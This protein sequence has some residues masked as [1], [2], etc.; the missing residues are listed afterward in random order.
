LITEYDGEE[1]CPSSLSQGNVRGSTV[2]IS[3]DG[4]T[5]QEETSPLSLPSLN[6]V[7]EVSFEWDETSISN[8][9]VTV[10]PSQFTVPHRSCFIGNP[11]GT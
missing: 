9:G 2:L 10:I 1:V 8:T 4:V 6:H 5:Q 3:Q 11:S 7:F